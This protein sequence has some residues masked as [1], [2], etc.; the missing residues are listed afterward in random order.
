MLCHCSCG[1]TFENSRELDLHKVFANV[2]VVF[3]CTSEGCEYVGQ[4]LQRTFAH[5]LCT[6]GAVNFHE[7]HVQGCKHF[8]LNLYAK[9][10]INKHLSQYH[11]R[12]QHKIACIATVS[13]QS[14]TRRTYCAVEGCTQMCNTSEG[15]CLHVL[16]F[17]TSS[18]Q[19][20]CRIKGCANEGWLFEIWIRYW[21]HTKSIEHNQAKRLN[22][23]YAVFA[24][25]IKQK[26]KER[27]E[28]HSERK[29]EI[30]D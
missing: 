27:F 13:T 2:P 15:L 26:Q 23:K 21:T 28:S 20:R 9:K 14:R 4:T 30:V 18:N 3:H 7:C 16:T 6:H 11:G 22:C 5:E 12:S 17:R 25:S 19:R 10:A 8:G 1:K 29:C 24:R